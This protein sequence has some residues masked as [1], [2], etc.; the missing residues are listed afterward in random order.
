MFMLAMRY[1]AGH[2]C[3]I[4]RRIVRRFLEV[5]FGD[6]KI[7]LSRHLGTVANPFADD[8]HR[9]FLGEFCLASASAV[10]QELR[11]GLQACPLDDLPQQ[12]AKVL[13]S[14]VSADN[15]DLSGFRL[16]EDFRQVRVA[17]REDRHLANAAVR[18]V[19]CLA[20]MDR[21]T[22][23]LPVHVFPSHAKHFRRATQAP[24]A[25][26]GED[27]SS[28]CIG[29]SG[30]NRLGFLA[31]DEV[32]PLG[33]LAYQRR[34]AVKGVCRYVS[35]TDRRPEEL[36]GNAATSPRRILGQAFRGCA[37]TNPGTSHA[38]ALSDFQYVRHR[39]LW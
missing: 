17:F 19:F 22:H 27:Q 10:L 15:A 23:L 38:A 21:E 4:L 34:Q 1:R 28:F 39:P 36:L 11:P 33:I 5:I 32:E 37:S 25:G 8:L 20:G 16:L 26:K 35:P 18:V 30:K 24:I 2:F 12:R 29:A 13:P 3:D 31:R 6:L 14:A 9:V 7:V